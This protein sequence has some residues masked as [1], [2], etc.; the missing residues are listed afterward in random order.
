VNRALVF[1][2]PT[3]GLLAVGFGAGCSALMSFGAISA[4]NP[5]TSGT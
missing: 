1:L 2:T 3:L 5:L 4:P